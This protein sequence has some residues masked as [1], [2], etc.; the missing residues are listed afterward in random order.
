MYFVLTTYH[1]KNWWKLFPLLQFGRY[2]EARMLELLFSR[3]GLSARWIT[4]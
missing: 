2:N 3:W 4:K 1:R